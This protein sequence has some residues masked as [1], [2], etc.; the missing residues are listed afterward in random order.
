M[1]EMLSAMRASG[2]KVNPSIVIS[3]ARALMCQ[4]GR[5][6]ELIQNGGHM[7]IN[8][9]WASNVLRYHLCWTQR[10]ATTDRKLTEDQMVLAADHHILLERK[11]EDYHPALAIEFDETLAPYCPM[12]DYTYAPENSPRV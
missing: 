5:G 6:G 3:V 1:K 10:R 4:S 2:S 12:N 8:K 11:S 9:D 7:D